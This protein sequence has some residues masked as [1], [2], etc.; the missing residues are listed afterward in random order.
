VLLLFFPFQ[1]F[2]N[3]GRSHIIALELKQPASGKGEEFF[4]LLI[5]ADPPGLK[6]KNLSGL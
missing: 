3:L 4:I 6:T 1:E 5:D 2:A